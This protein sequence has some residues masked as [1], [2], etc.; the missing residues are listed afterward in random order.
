M[1]QPHGNARS[2]SAALRSYGRAGFLKI[3]PAVVPY[4]QPDFR[5][6]DEIDRT[7]LRPVP[8]A[9]VVRRVGSE[10]ERT[11]PSS[12]VRAIIAALYTMFGLHVRADHMAPLR[13][14]LDRFPSADIPLLPPSSA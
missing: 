4:R 8:Y 11:L 12:E 5:A 14:L 7:S 1:E 13:A 10:A 6:A 2:N 3:D 9:L